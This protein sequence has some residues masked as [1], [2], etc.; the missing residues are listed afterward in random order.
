MAHS[1]SGWHTAAVALAPA[2]LAKSPAAWPHG[3]SGAEQGGI[4]S[5]FSFQRAERGPDRNLT[6]HGA[7]VTGRHCD[8]AVTVTVTLTAGPGR[9]SPA[10]SRVTARAGPPDREAPRR[11]VSRPTT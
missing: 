9:G 10:H 8:R 4:C 6:A 7:T 2:A 1:H 5:L 3:R 11:Q